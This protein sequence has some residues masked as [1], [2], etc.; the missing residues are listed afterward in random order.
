MAKR[1]QALSNLDGKTV[2][3][4]QIDPQNKIQKAIV[5]KVPLYIPPTRLLGVAGITQATRCQARVWEEGNL[6]TYDTRQIQI[7]MAGPVPD[8]I[9]LGL[10]GKYQVRP[11]IPE[12]LRCFKCQRYG[13]H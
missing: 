13:H 1:L 12:P 9:D 7:Q 4:E 8:E 2:Q 10:L 5:T 3:L 6:K 11:F